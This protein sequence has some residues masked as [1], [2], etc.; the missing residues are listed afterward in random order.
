LH[1]LIFM[2]KNRR[3]LILLPVVVVASLWFLLD[4][5]PAWSQRAGSSSSHGNKNSGAIGPAIPVVTTKVAQLDVPIYL[6]GIGTVQAYN[7]VNMVPQ[8]AGYLA[9]VYFTEG[10]EVK[11]GDILEQI[12]PRPYQATYDQAVAKRN[13]DVATYNS[14]RVLLDRDTLL[15]QAKPPVIDKS[16]YDT[17]RYLVQQ[18]AATVKADEAAVVSAQV[19]LDFTKITAPFNGRCG[20]RL[21]DQGNYVATSTTLLT[22]T[23]LKPISVLFTVAG[24]YVN[25]I[26]EAVAASQGK[27]LITQAVSSD[28]AKVIDT[29]LMAVMNNQ[30]NQTTNTV[31]IKANFPNVNLRLW[32]GEFVNTRLLLKIDKSAM[33]V[34]AAA[35]QRG[36]NGAFVYVITG[37]KTAE[38]LPVIPGKIDSGIAIVKTGLHP[39]QEVVIDGQS[40]LQ[41]GA[42]VATTSSPPLKPIPLPDTTTYLPTPTPAALPHINDQTPQVELPASP[43]T[44]LPIGSQEI[45]GNTGS[46]LFPTRLPVAKPGHPRPNHRQP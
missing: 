4:K 45:P 10:Q 28:Q 35:I 43:P 6:D 8:V 18:N 30:I 15:M 34:P 36:P 16:T 39:G 25:D 3:L 21:V 31:Q 38:M 20:I 19:N 33:V 2:F 44:S 37:Q 27:P 11:Q 41:P 46:Q 40:R 12:D 14:N 23:Q 5:R 7:T 22:I 17:Q 24:K 26:N 1:I 9:K 32:P 42:S 29:G 13:A